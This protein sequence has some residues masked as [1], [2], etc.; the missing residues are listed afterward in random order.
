MRKIRLFTPGPTPLIPEGQL[1]Q[2][3]PLI[4]HRTPEFKAVMLEIRNNLRKIFRTESEIV[5]LSSSGTGAMEAAVANLHAPGEKVIAVV[6]GKFGER[7]AELAKAYGLQC[8][9]LTKEYGEAASAEEIL[10]VLRREGDAR[11]VLLQACE[12][13]TATAHDLEAVGKAVRREFPDVLIVVDAI[14]AV[15][16][17]PL[18]PDDWGLDVVIG[19]SQKAFG[20]P[21]GLAFLSLSPRAL[22]K[23]E[24]VP[25]GRRYYFDLR[26]ELKNQLVG[27]TAY[28]P[29]ISLIVGL[30][31]VTKRMLDEGLDEIIRT[32]GLM[33]QATREGLRALGFRLLSSSPANAVTA[34]FPPEGIA[35]DDLRKDLDQVFGVKVAGG[36]GKLKGQ[37]IRIAHLGYFD[38]LD[39]VTVLAAVELALVRRGALRESGRGVQAALQVLTAG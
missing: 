17:Q 5:L 12:T 8:I 26:K 27:S 36:Q 23:L 3:R 4:H 39:V 34:A 28:T 1:A 15:A 2:A 25:A 19:G 6:A 9:E 24:T 31:E 37:I 18:L 14:T 16:C 7:W 35:A 38:V 11:S 13:S 21:P 33:A 10:Q 29:A 30:N 22:G 20:M 32:A